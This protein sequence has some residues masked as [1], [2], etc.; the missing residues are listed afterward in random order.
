MEAVIILATHVMAHGT[1]TSLL[2]GPRWTVH[3]TRLSYTDGKSVL[4]E[5]SRGGHRL[6]V[7]E[8]T[9]ITIHRPNKQREKE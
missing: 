9:Q 2:S 6:R 4:P 1:V 7:Y 5:L 8:K 3:F